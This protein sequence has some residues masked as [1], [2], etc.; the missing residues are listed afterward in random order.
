MITIR[1]ATLNDGHALSHIDTLCTQGKGVVFHY[2]RPNFF[3]R[4]GVYKRWSSFIAEEGNTIVGTASACLKKINIAGNYYPAGYVYDLRIHPEWRRQGISYRLLEAAE[5]YLRHEGVRF[6]Y[7]Y[8][9]DVNVIA[10]R[11]C[12]VFGMQPAGCYTSL[13][14]PCFETKNAHITLITDE[15]QPTYIKQIEER[16]KYYD[17]AEKNSLSAQYGKP[18]DNA[19][20]L[21]IFRS[22]KDKDASIS[23]WDSSVL[24]TKVV[25]RIPVALRILDLT[26]G[27]LRKKLKLP[28]LPGKNKPL[29]IWQ[30]FDIWSEEDDPDIIQSLVKGV[31]NLAYKEGIHMLIMYLDTNDR[32]NSILRPLAGITMKG[33]VLM[34][35]P[36]FGEKPPALKKIYLDVRDF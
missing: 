28:R 20:F 6:A 7:T 11:V 13:I 31:Q 1:K 30:L 16:Q 25:D 29:R 21:G 24:S 18:H 32:L 14:F 4:S 27:W 36:R 9:L 33:F 17:L 35:T 8:I 23:I 15:E 5:T 2:Q 3:A 22:V 26:G 10:K 12:H 19:P 34:R